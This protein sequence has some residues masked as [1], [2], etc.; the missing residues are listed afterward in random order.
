M[1]GQTGHPPMYTFLTN[2]DKGDGDDE[3]EYITSDGF[4]IFTV[5]LSKEMQSFVDVVLT[6]RLEQTQ[7]VCVCV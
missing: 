2:E 1:R 5:T 6:Q 7:S 4:V 3:G